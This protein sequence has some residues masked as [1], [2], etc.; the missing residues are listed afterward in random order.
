[1]TKT[2][3]PETF[4]AESMSTI[5]SSSVRPRAGATKEAGDI[6]QPIRSGLLKPEAI[7]ADLH[8]LARTVS[9]YHNSA[10][11]ALHVSDYTKGNPDRLGSNGAVRAVALP[12]KVEQIDCSAIVKGFVEHSYYLDGRVT[13]VDAFSR[14]GELAHG[15][16]HTV[17]L[18]GG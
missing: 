4:T 17:V 5:R 3:A 6:V 9:I 10:D 1:M 2:S 15:Q 7:V 8:E 12:D 14:L 18:H 13:D 16:L 11:M